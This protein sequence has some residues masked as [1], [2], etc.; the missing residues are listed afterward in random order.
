MS[1]K[2]VCDASQICN[3]NTKRCV[4]KTGKVGKQILSALKSSQAQPPQPEVQPLPQTTKVRG[5]V[6]SDRSIFY[7]DPNLY[8]YLKRKFGSY[9]INDID[10]RYPIRR[11]I[12]TGRYGKIL[13]GC[14]DELFDCRVFKIQKINDNVLPEYIYREI[15]MQKKMSDIGLAPAI[16]DYDINK[17][18][19]LIEMEKIDG[20][21]EDILLEKLDNDT[22]DL[23]IRQV[24][25]IID[26]LCKNGVVHGDMHWGN[27]GFRFIVG[28]YDN[29]LLQ[30]MLIDYGLSCCVDKNI[31]CR[32]KLEYAQLIRTLA[33]EYIDMNNYNRLYLTKKL[34]DIWL[35]KF[36]GDYA[37]DLL[38]EEIWSLFDKIQLK[39]FR[40]FED[41]SIMS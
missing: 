7:S 33:P 28:K 40:G 20:V 1:C 41:S 11:Y 27:I 14:G 6:P 18:Y 13:V 29:L 5:Y 23:I 17:N 34:Y 4:S 21:I 35:N 37:H 12:D 10:S 3:S 9:I 22:L 32:P 38:P 15:Q 16:F 26:L 19:F 25:D 2:K 8:L 36:G 39:E 31:G 24:S 30:S